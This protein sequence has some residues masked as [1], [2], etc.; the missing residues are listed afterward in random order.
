MSR[1]CEGQNLVPNWSFE[2]TLHCP[3]YPDIF[4]ANGWMAYRNTPGYF[5]SCNLN[6]LAGVPSNLMGFQYPLTGNAFAGIVTFSK[7]YVDHRDI[8]G[9]QLAQPLSIGQKYF[10]SFF[11]SN[12]CDSSSN[13][14]MATNKIGAKCSM[15]PYWQSNPIPI[16]NSAHVYSDSIIVDSLNWVKISG[17]FIAD[18]AYLFFSLGNFFTDSAT[19]KVYFD[20]TADVAYYYVDDIRL[21]TDSNFVNSISNFNHLNQ[22]N[23]FPN[24]FR[25]RLEI[26]KMNADPTEVI[27]YD[28]TSRRIIQQN[29]TNS[30]SLNTAP[31]AKGLYIY[32]IRNKNGVIKKG[33]VVKN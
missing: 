20:S 9:I 31:F 22:V 21:S 2:D 30:I 3:A 8:A 25:E 5:N 4:E 29:F 16:N 28:L 6:G 13:K 14:N 7:L 15:D 33:K 10:L 32:E 12:S 18:S 11:V 24:P 19:T 26:K 17:S 27:L 23:I 1:T